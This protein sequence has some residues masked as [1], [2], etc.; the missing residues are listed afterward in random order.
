MIP[1]IIKTLIPRKSIAAI[2][3]FYFATITVIV[4]LDE[5]NIVFTVLQKLSPHMLM[6][7]SMLILA[8]CIFLLGVIVA[9]PSEKKIDLYKYKFDERTGLYIFKEN[10]Q[11]VCSSCLLERNRHTP[12]REGAKYYT[13]MISTCRAKYPNPKYR[14]PEIG[15]KE[16]SN[17]RTGWVHEY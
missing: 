1:T 2:T 10:G 11:L 5:Q 12:V 4:K 17:D 15:K 14:H 7:I 9:M 3:M 8:T 13:C 6:T 16:A